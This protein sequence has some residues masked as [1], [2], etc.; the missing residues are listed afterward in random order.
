LNP[1]TGVRA[2]KPS[3]VP[4]L[5]TPAALRDELVVR[6]KSTGFP[7][8]T[9]LKPK[10]TPVPRSRAVEPARNAPFGKAVLNAACVN[11]PAA[12]R[13]CAPVNAVS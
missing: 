12:T 13:A 5:I 8:K 10:A 7:V 1:K 6:F 2:S 11:V 4:P 3:S 9:L